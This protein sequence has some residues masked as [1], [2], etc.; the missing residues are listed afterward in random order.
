MFIIKTENKMKKSIIAIFILLISLS[1]SAQKGAEV[2]IFAGTSFYLGEVNQTKLFYMPSIAVG[3]IY[4]HTLNKRWAIRFD[5]TY[6]KLKGKDSKSNNAYQLDRNHEFAT[7]IGDISFQIE[8]NFL[9]YDRE[10]YKKNYFTPYITTGIS[11]LIIPEPKYPFE[12]AI[13]FGFGLKYGITKK[14]TLSAE[15]SFRYTHSDYIDKIET[16]NFSSTATNA[17]KQNSY[18]PDNDIYSFVGLSI[19]FNLFSEKAVCPA[20]GK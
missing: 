2:G 4:R 18:N 17:I 16:D 6:T 15:W 3:G 5:G 9:P 12:F 14:I 13:P 1:L 20:F 8:L 11:L 10:A 19:A 7:K